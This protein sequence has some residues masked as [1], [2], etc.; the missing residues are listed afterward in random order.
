MLPRNHYSTDG[1]TGNG[2]LLIRFLQ[3]L[4]NDE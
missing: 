1:G 4:E 3:T 2:L